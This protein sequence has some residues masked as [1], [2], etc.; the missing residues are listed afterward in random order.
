MAQLTGWLFINSLYFRTPVE[1]GFREGLVP[2]TIAWT[3]ASWVI[4]VACSSALAT[5]Y[6]RMPPRWLTG[7]RVILVALGLSSVAALPWAMVMTLLVARTA[8]ADFD[9]SFGSWFFFQAT[10]LMA[11][12]SSVFI[13]FVHG[14]RA[15]NT[16]GRALRAEALAPEAADDFLEV[17]ATHMEVFRPALDP[18]DRAR[19]RLRERRL[20]WRWRHQRQWS[21]E[22]NRS[23]R[24]RSRSH[25]R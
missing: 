20:E 1:S 11:A 21:H 8:P 16:Q 3:S 5:V 14:D 17:D 18:A 4:A 12:W 6:L 13:W 10:L 7:V 25:G 24:G 2:L 9:Q 23:R 19:V 22:R 15:P